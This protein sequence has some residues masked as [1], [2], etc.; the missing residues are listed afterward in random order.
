QYYLRQRFYD[1]GVGRF[2]RRDSYEGRIGEPITL[3]K[4]LYGNANPVAFVDPSGLYSIAEANAAASIAN[5]LAGI[6]LET[7]GY[8]LSGTLSRGEYNSNNFTLELA[9]NAMFAIAPLFLA[10]G[11]LGLI[12][13]LIGGRNTKHRIPSAGAG[14]NW[15]TI[16][17]VSDIAVTRQY[18]R[19]ACG[20]ACGSMA[21]RDRAVYVSQSQVASQ[22][23][24]VRT[25]PESLAEA[26]NSLST[27]SGMRW[28]GAGVS[29]ES[30]NPLNSTGSWIAMVRGAND[31]HWV[32]VDG[33]DDI[34]NLKIRDPF[35][36][37]SYSVTKQDF[38]DFWT[39]YVVYQQS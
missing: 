19:N 11:A 18:T 26:L 30:I 22:A 23:G 29:N 17:E 35:E 21:L 36:G 13:G 25:H 4:Y 31:N 1:A 15:P 37:T 2:T 16:D 33:F 12:G 14:L 9:S 38:L 7:G 20:P 24:R 39:N 3:H 8:L 6:Q 10:S 28:R 5:T 34:G 32:I 27:S